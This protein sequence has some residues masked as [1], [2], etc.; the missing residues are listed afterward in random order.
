[1][2]ATNTTLSADDAKKQ[3]LSACTLL[4]MPTAVVDSHCHL[5][6]L[7]V[8][9]TLDW[10]EK[11]ISGASIVLCNEDFYQQKAGRKEV[12]PSLK[13]KAQLKFSLGI[14]PRFAAKL[15]TMNLQAFGELV[16]EGKF[17][18]IGETGLCTRWMKDRDEPVGLHHQ[19]KLFKF[20]LLLAKASGL[21]LVLH[22]RSN[23]NLDCIVTAS[24]IMKN[25]HLSPDHPINIHCFTGS[26]ESA[27]SFLHDWPSTIFGSGVYILPKN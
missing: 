26:L 23:D 20:H 22:L 19:T 8:G 4:T 3:L 14:H 10:V 18:A 11:N 17:H 16:Q 12:S 25:L 27:K 5:S 2:A 21:P 7:P 6:Q 24:N 15:Y 9:N 13:E 1:M